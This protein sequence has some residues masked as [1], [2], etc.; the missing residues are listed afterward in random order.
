M[1]YIQDVTVGRLN[2]GN[3]GGDIAATIKR[4]E[5]SIALIATA[6]GAVVAIGPLV[7]VIVIGVFVSYG[8]S[9][10]DEHFG[11]TDKVIAALDEI[12]EKSIQG[13]IE[14][15]KAAIVHKGQQFADEAVESVIEY[16]MEK[17]ESIAIHTFRKILRNMS[18]PQI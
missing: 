12:S 6:G 2:K 9:K 7:A 5:S 11:I 15:K 16:A 8:L 18:I 13:I 10:L 1:S 4:T 3:H 17:V 14:E